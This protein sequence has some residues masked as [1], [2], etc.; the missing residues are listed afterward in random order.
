MPAGNSAGKWG[1]REITSCKVHF[2]DHIWSFSELHPSHTHSPWNIIS[3]SK[4]HPANDRST[5]S[6]SLSKAITCSWNAQKHGFLGGEKQSTPDCP[7]KPKPSAMILPYVQWENLEKMRLFFLS[8]CWSGQK[9]EKSL[10]AQ[11]ASAPSIRQLTVTNCQGLCKSSSMS[12]WPVKPNS[13]LTLSQVS[14]RSL[15]FTAWHA[16]FCLRCTNGCFGPSLGHWT[17][18]QHS[19]LS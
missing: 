8:C 11:R 13:N 14:Q 7:S 10:Q 3:L 6:A 5:Y 19:Y 4:A 2:F 16:T 9:N 18:V 1:S 17:P 15:T 12:L